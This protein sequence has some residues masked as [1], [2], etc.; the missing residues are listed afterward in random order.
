MLPHALSLVTLARRW[1]GELSD[2]SSN[3]TSSSE[4]SSFLKVIVRVVKCMAHTSLG[5]CRRK[6]D[7]PSAFSVGH[8]PCSFKTPQERAESSAPRGADC[9]TAHGERPQLPR[10]ANQDCSGFGINKVCCCKVALIF[11]A[12]TQI[13]ASTK[14]KP[15]TASAEA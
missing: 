2:C 4:R 13:K 12:L 10:W 6:P 1:L 5:C 8:L 9:S 3:S 15:I 7:A 11:G 14:T